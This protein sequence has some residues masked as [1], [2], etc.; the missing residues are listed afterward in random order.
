MLG[1]E[2]T[3]AG[4]GGQLE[5]VLAAAARG[6]CM[7]LSGA[8]G[9]GKT[10]LAREV[11]TRLRAAGH[12]A[13]WVTATRAGSAIP[14]G[15]VSH[16]LPEGGQA[17]RL[18][19][20]RRVAA[21]FERAERPAIVVD[22]AHLLDDASATVVHHLSTRSPAFALLTIRDGEHCPDAI[23]ALWK[24]GQ[25][26]RVT[27]PKLPGS[28]I[29]SLL[30]ETFEQQLDAVSRQRLSRVS[31]GNPLLLREILQAGFDSG[32]LRRRRGRWRWT[33][34]VPATARLGEVVADRLNAA[35]DAIA[36]VLEV[37]ACGEPLAMTVLE[38]LA[39]TEAITAA[40]R[41]G[42][43]VIDHSGNRVLARLSHPLHGEVI[44]S[45]M[46]RSRTRHLAGK[47]AAA[48]ISS[49]MRRRD[50]ALRAGVWQ[51]MAGHAGNAEILLTAAKQAMDRFDLDLAER[52]AR[53]SRDS[54]GGWR[55]E[56]VLAQILSHAGQANSDILYWGEGK[57][58]ASEEISGAPGRRAAEGNRSFILMFDSRCADALKVGE[59]VLATPDAEPQA[60]VWAATGAGAAAGL[61]GDTARASAIYRLGLDVATVHQAEVPWGAT[62]V[63]C[64]RLMGLLANARL[65]EARELAER[66]YKAALRD[67]AE[68]VVGAWAGF[69]GATAKAQG[70]VRVAAS[71]LRESLSLLK[72]Y[73]AFR[74]AAPCL[75]SLAGAL[76]LSGDGRLAARLLDRAHSPERQASRLFQPWM[77]LDK[78]WTLAA[79]G[80]RSAAASTARAAADLARDFGQPTVEGWALYDAA[81][82]GDAP[83]VHARL[84]ALGSLFA[85]AARGLAAKDPE[86]LEQAAWIFADRGLL[87]HAAEAAATAGALYRSD[88][89]R[90]LA[91]VVLERAA[92]LAQRCH[93]AHTPL[94]DASGLRA[95]LTRREHEVAALAVAGLSSR[96]IAEQ[97]GLSVRTVDN[98]LGRA[99][100]KF[101]VR[102]RAELSRAFHP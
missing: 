41:Q 98:Y 52:L 17:D 65:S 96:R 97:L 55:A 77:E 19:L 11:W 14:F 40:E 35:G 60:V 89:K 48:T 5:T 54:G 79:L 10:R 80:N 63:G 76:A 91:N 71:S 99:Y 25:A 7:V 50:D 72:E 59:S 15:A 51:L 43:A 30:A 31:G 58:R 67:E 13:E 46:T 68:N 69:L 75:A 53:A 42:L 24:E 33:G 83:S 44:R 39:S 20:L 38:G 86:P 66:E 84:T 82:L 70:D 45:T 100:A 1:Q 27:V 88:G 56:N 8:A 57:E 92:V 101:G 93:G 16:L 32:T 95:V 49:P 61:L 36:G 2:W 85:P 29:D 74:L 18:A 6:E 9:I 78:A 23:T 64:G 12:T 37:I 4:R 28:A 73:D 102:G 62:Q 81:R 34:S 90:T 47:L 22:D 87:L 26:T 3:L 94:L 21:Q